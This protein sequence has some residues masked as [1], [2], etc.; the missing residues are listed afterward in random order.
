M[1]ISLIVLAGV[2]FW[3]F[4]PEVA[5]AVKAHTFGCNDCHKAAASASPRAMGNLCVNCHTGTGPTAKFTTGDASNAMGHNPGP[6][7]GSGGETSHFWGGNSTLQ[8]AAGSSNPSSTFYTSRYSISKNRITCTICHDPHGEAT[9]KLVRAAIAGDL[10]CQQCHGSWFVANPNATLTHPIVADYAAIA[11]ANPSKFNATV[12]N[13]GGGDVR[14][15]NG[16]VSCTSCHGTHYADSSSA[17]TDGTTNY[18]N[19]TLAKGDGSILR[20]DGP[21]RTGAARDTAVTG[22]AQLR[23]NLCQA[24]HTYKMHGKGGN[25]QLIGCLDC[26]GGHGYNGGVANAFVLASQSPDAVPVRANRAANGTASV[27]FPS[28]PDG[29][30]TRTK[31]SDDNAGTANGFCE[32]CHGDVQDVGAGGLGNIDLQH[33]AGQTT[34]CDN[35]HL[36]G[37]PGFSFANDANAATCGACHGFPP[38]K[39]IIGIR[40]TIG[41]ANDGGYAAIAGTYNYSADSGHYKDETKTAHK[42]HAGAALTGNPGEW[43]FVGTSGIANCKVCH[44]DSAGSPAG[45]HQVPP[46]TDPNTFRNVPFNTVAKAGTNLSPSFNTT[47][48]K[49]YNVY[50]HSNGAPRTGNG[51][52]RSYATVNTTPAWVGTGADYAGGGYGSIFLQAGSTRCADCHGNTAATMSSKNNSARHQEH[53][54]GGEMGITFGCDVCHVDTAASATALAAGATDGRSGGEHVN[55]IVDVAYKTSGVALYTALATNNNG[56]SY[57]SASGTCSIYCHDPSDTGNTADWDGAGGTQCDTCHGG[58]SADTAGDGGVGPIT[59]GSHSRHILTTGTGPK[60]TCAECHGVGADTGT[61]VGHINGGNITMKVAVNTA[62]FGSDS[63]S[64]CKECHG[65]DAEPGEVLPVWGNSGTTDC[66][67]CHAGNFCGETINGKDP[68]GVNYARTTGHN[69]PSSAGAYA[70]SANVAANLSCSS[71]HV[72][73]SSSHWN[74]VSGDSYMLKNS[75]GFPATYAGNE[76]TFCGNCHGAAGTAVKKNINTHQSKLCVACHNVHGDQNIQMIWTTQADQVSHDSSSGKYAADVFF[77]NTTNF[78]AG[79]LNSYDEDDGAAGS[80]DEVNSDDICA[81]CHTSAGGSAHN[82]S[83][84][85]DSQAPTGHKMGLDC[86][87]CHAAHTDATNAFKLGAGT[88]CN[89]C[90]GFPPATGAHR[91]GTLLTDPELHSNTTSNSK[92]VE[93]RTDCAFCHTGADQYTYDLG[94]DQAAGGARGNHA[95]SQAI[96]QSVLAA[97]VGYNS[98]NFNCTTACHAS[99]AGDGAWN[100]TTGLDCNACHYYSATPTMAGNVTASN[101]EAVSNVHNKHFDKSKVCIDCHTIENSGNP[102]R[103]QLVHINAPDY[104]GAGNDGTLVQG[105]A[106]AAQDAATVVRTGMTFDDNLNTCAGGIGLGCHASGTPDWDITIPA[107]SAGCVMCH[108]ET[109]NSAFNPVSGIHDNSPSGPT[110]TGNA[111]DGSFDNG[112]AGTADCVTCHTASPTVS[113]TDHINGNFD[114]SINAVAAPQKITLVAGL[115][116]TDGVTPT[117]A[118][119]LAG[120]HSAGSTWAYQWTTD[121]YLNDNVRECNGCHGLYSGIANSQGWRTGTSHA[122]GGYQNRGEKHNN[123]GTS[124]Y[125][126]DDCHAIGSAGYTFAPWKANKHGDNLLQLNNHAEHDW[127]DAGATIGCNLSCHGDDAAHNLP[128]PGVFTI[129]YAIVGNRAAVSCS[130]CHGGATTG[131]IANY[132]PDGVNAVNDTFEDNSGAH[133]KHMAV[134]ALKVYGETSTGAASNDIL[135]NNTALNPGVTSDTKQKELCTYCHGDGSNPIVLPHGNPA[136]DLPAEV[137]TMY[138]LWDKSL[139]N[140]SFAIAGN[141]TCATVDCHNNVTTPTSP[142]NFSWYGG[143]T[144]ACVMCH[145]DVTNGA[146]ANSN[147]G[148]HVAHTSASTTFGRVISCNDCHRTASETIAWGSPGTAPTNSHINGTFTVSSNVVTFTYSGGSCGT[149]AC[150]N[151]GN[152]STAPATPSY[153]WGT[154]LANC[155]ICHAAVPTVTAAHTPHLG[156]ATLVPNGCNECHDA[157]NVSTHIDAKIDFGGVVS[158]PATNASYDGSCTNTCHVAGGGDWSGGAAALAC[159][160]CHAGSYVGGNNWRA[161]GN[162]Y[163]AQS[164]LHAMTA[165]NVTSHNQNLSGGCEACHSTYAT[166]PASHVNNIWEADAATQTD[167][168]FVSRTNMTYTELAANSS[169]CSG[170]GLSGCHADGGKW[171]RL[172][173]TAANSDYVATP[174][175]GQAVCNVCH[176]SYST[177]TNSTGWRAGT[178]HALSGASKGNGHADANSECEDCHAYPGVTG[179]HEDGF[180]TMSGD[181]NAVLTTGEDFQ[182]AWGTHGTNPGWYCSSCHTGAASD[183]AL[184][185]T[186]HTFVD[187]LAFPS[188]TKTPPHEKIRY[189][190][191]VSVP[192]GGCTGCH[193]NTGTGGYWPDGSKG[194]VRTAGSSGPADRPGKHAQHVKEIAKKISPFPAN[195][196]AAQMNATCNYCHPNPGESGHNDT[197][198]PA[199]MHDGATTKFKRIITPYANDNNG[200]VSGQGTNYVTCTNIDCHFNMPRTPQWYTDNLAP[201]VVSL[202]AVPGPYPRSIKVSWNAPGDDNNDADTTPYVYD[203][204]YSTVSGTGANAASDYTSTSNYAG[205]LPAAYKQGSLSE[206]IIQN[207]NPGTTYYFS[208]KSQDTTGTWSGASAEASAQPTTDTTPPAFGGANAAIKGDASQT[209]YLTWTPAEDHTMPITYKVWRKAKSLGALDMDTDPV[210]LTGV[211][212]SSIQLT[213]AAPDSLVNDTIYYFGVRACDANN[214]C[215]TNDQIVSATPTA[216]PEVIKTNHTYRTN[217]NLTLVKDGSAG[218]AVVGATLGTTGIVFA[219]AA[220]NTYS[221]TY[222]VDT[223]AV[224]LDTANGAATV[225]AEI[226]YS[227]TGADFTSLGV[228]KDITLGS[229]ADRI[230]SFKLVDVAGKTINSG[231]RLAIR[232]SEPSTGI[233]VKANYGSTAYRG[234]ITV[235]ERILNAVPN[236]PA[237]AATVSGANLNITWSNTG[238]GSD[239]LSDTVHYDLFGSDDNGTTYRYLIAKG[240]PAGTVNYTWNTQLAG[241]S[242]SATMAV[243]LLAGD[244]YGHYTGAG[245][246]VTG[247]GVNNSA[248]LVAPGAITDLVARARPKSGSVLLTW[249][250]QGDDSYNNGRAKYYDIR[251]DTRQIVETGGNGTTTVNF[252]DIPAT[253]TSTSGRCVNEPSPDFGGKVQTFEVTGLTPGTNYYFAIKTYDEGGNAS[254]ISSAKAAGTDQAPGGPRCGMCHTTAPSIVESVGNHKLHGFTLYDCT[255]CHGAAVATYPL[256]HQDGELVMG[257]GP[258]GPN[259]GIVSGNRIYYTND[260]TPGGTVLYDDTDGFGG[261]GSGDYVSTGDLTDNGSCSGWSALGVNGCHSAA[262]TDPDGAGSKFTTL[263]LSVP[264]WTSVAYLNCASCHGN[265]DRTVDS[266]YGRAFDATTANA[267]V[268]PDQIKAAPSMDNRGN[269]KDDPAQTTGTFND[270][271]AGSRK[272]IGQHEKHL[273][274]SFRFSKG[275]NCN[276]CHPGDYKNANNLDGKHANGEVNIKL[277]PVGAGANAQWNPGTATTPG[278]CTNLSADTCHPSTGATPYW[279]TDQAFDCRNCHGMGG[280]T[281]SHVT[282]PAGA[283]FVNDGLGN[284][285]WCHFGGHPRDNVGGAALILENSSQVGINYRSDGI[286][287]RKSIGGRAA[288]QT[289]AELCWACHDSQSTKI[290]EWGTDTGGNNV[291]TRPPNSRDYNYGIV[292]SGTSS[293]WIASPG[294]GATWSSAYSTAAGFTDD[295]FGYKTGAIRSTHSTNETGTSAVT[296]AMGSYTENVD[297]VAKIR[298]SNCHDVHNLNKAPGDTMTGQPY[299]RGSWIRNPYLEDGAPWGKQYQPSVAIYGLVPRA[300]GS[301]MGGYQ[302]DQNNSYPTAGMSLATSAGLC[303]L[304]HGTNI[305]AMDKTTGEALWIGTNGHSNATLGGTASAAA[306]IFGNG[307]GGRPIPNGNWT[308]TNSNAADIPDMGLQAAVVGSLRGYSYR[309]A[310]SFNSPRTPIIGAAQPYAYDSF[311]WGVSVDEGTTDIGY[312]AF[313]C[314]KCHNPHASRLPKLMITNCLDTRHNTWQSSAAPNGQG[315]QTLPTGWTSMTNIDVGEMAATWSTAQNCHRYDTNDNVGGWNKVTPW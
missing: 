137:N 274:Y 64:I 281:P 43:Y 201:A 96:R 8:A 222:Y 298:C 92:D 248:D 176:G 7:T 273:N 113:P 99:S 76:N 220:N 65:Y 82:N 296:G 315:N 36:H 295:S 42:T 214:N 308:D 132:W 56:V 195:P 130:G 126:C 108:T 256:D 53:L 86:F 120:C 270:G 46:G 72:T 203:L 61:H 260:G 131:D 58:T 51:P 179:K 70:Q 115:G 106:N 217:G 159:T 299:L 145:V 175:T 5:H 304:C 24:C 310:Q 94:L 206:A 258:G 263:Q 109:N 174:S 102:L 136:T 3:C 190:D 259:K 240:L 285:E 219:P 87:V 155:T 226:G 264:T 268:V 153:P 38:Y 112:A 98:T 23:S 198:A 170:T 68:V 290:S 48:N 49:C 62:A 88:A 238:D 288:Q 118:E 239:G 164:G 167:S 19:A 69:R 230:Y 184:T 297:D 117:C 306:N 197:T 40:S 178:V 18:N 151:A 185:G 171:S 30:S 291:S 272:Y 262:G 93:D 213:G 289:E 110:V 90:H 52:T 105:R 144:S 148:T 269:W 231:Q 129:N 71:C 255:K 100:D 234:D 193:G 194:G 241:I 22:T 149:N 161:S 287:L 67:T 4:N 309:N 1:K 249:T 265:P 252:A 128:D 79:N 209:V 89:D 14:L 35:C 135:R 9:T 300:G 154:A 54:G 152:G 208:L 27:D 235:A 204:R 200:A 261:F 104:T 245:S 188:P 73:D 172:W 127:V 147:G 114:H 158:A 162:N 57:D 314:S 221:V 78:T 75:A 10:I 311:F 242:G 233:G 205:N 138:K 55:S 173:S 12:T 29:G 275:D 229:R 157:A 15:V 16:G 250:A 312:H 251:Y 163:L 39:D 59:S 111:H 211:K 146:V 26:H 95:K 101:S 210:L 119:N 122:T 282:D 257:Y 47:D 227:T 177:I 313:T 266:F 17:T 307:I 187:S 80:A 140:G 25:N 192:E 45:G 207:L 223:F 224:Y 165:T 21:L 11:A 277:D 294:V 225:R 271:N 279:D 212:G 107:T 74:G 183:D 33:Q 13:V 66:A 50:C 103:G 125:P 91:K 254:A 44:G 134:L 150:H 31:W 84:N 237:V 284:C 246:T 133:A 189:V 160:D 60:L 301:E 280:V 41:D 253:P 186:S 292:N 141:K 181:T 286:H 124:P 142:T 97:S 6:G 218:T 303:T 305:D 180:I 283:G 2:L 228:S 267:G 244:G 216:E 83:D 168:R 20:S 156:N 236:N 37:D 143:G 182:L 191:G 276:L 139:D 28:F 293:K 85:T 199:T 278:S 247:K 81:T 232:L 169:T 123:P 243:K 202:T 121:A 302:I 196:S 32:S 166:S 63:I 34:E 215:D 77:T 116:F